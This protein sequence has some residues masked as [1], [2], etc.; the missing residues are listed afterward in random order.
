MLAV[1]D[2]E[3]EMLKKT[4]RSLAASVGVKNPQDLESV[5]EEKAWRAL[6]DT[7]FLG[8]RL[9]QDGQP[10]ASGVEAMIVAQELGG[11]LA[12]TP[13]LWSGLLAV[14]LL[15][16]AGLSDI[17]ES[18]AGGQERP[19]LLLGTDLLGLAGPDDVHAVL[20]GGV[21]PDYALA[22]RRDGSGGRLVRVEVGDAFAP[23]AAADF[24]AHVAGRVAGSS[25]A[26]EDIGQP[27]AAADLDRWLALALTAVSADCAGSI[28]SALDG[29][30][31]YTKHRIAY[32]VPIGSFQALQH[33]C[34]DAFAA[35]EGAVT[36]NSYAAWSVDGLDPREALLAARTAK[37]W[38]ASVAREVAETV[39][40]IYGGIG[41]TWE[42]IAHIYAR[43]AL[44]DT[45]LFGGE[46]YQLDQIY[47]MRSGGN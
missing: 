15:E 14:E 5:D 16:L 24:T 31:D 2:P 21:Q 43:R 19:G 38:V 12:A 13:F 44:F 7:G 41:Q 11:A 29:V 9:R 22:M 42:H 40:Q 45:A 26:T 35:C 10:L 4:A 8:L 1:L 6:T 36:T 47:A 3:Q 20:V 18:V 25:V 17:A 28:R 33:L 37:A 39:M 32:E 34:A 30:V 46:N 27:I 23:R